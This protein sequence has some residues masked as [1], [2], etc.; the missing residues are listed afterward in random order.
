[1]GKRRQDRGKAGKGNEQ[2]QDPSRI[3]RH[4]AVRVE[5]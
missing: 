4:A 2:E 5:P 3:D 1:V